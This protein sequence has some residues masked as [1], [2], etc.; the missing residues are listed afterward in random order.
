MV[1]GKTS[2]GM[3]LFLIIV[4]HGLAALAVGAGKGCLDIFSCQLFLSSSL[5]LGYSTIK[6]EILSQRAAKP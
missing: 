5:S 2:S 3:A 6:T 4:G 1:L